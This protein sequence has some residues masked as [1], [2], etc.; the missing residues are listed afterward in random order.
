MKYQYDEKTGVNL[1]VKKGMFVITW[2]VIAFIL[3]GYIAVMCQDAIK[4][5]G[6]FIELG[7]SA[8]GIIA[9]WYF[10]APFLVNEANKRHRNPT[11]PFVYGIAVGWLGLLP[12]GFAA[13][14]YLVCLLIVG[15]KIQSEKNNGP[16]EVI[17]TK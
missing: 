5:K 13:C 4:A 7:G 14:I 16:D 15:D 11:I 2:I 17:D 6:Q 9:G 12:G 3:L 10:F 8:L 1:T